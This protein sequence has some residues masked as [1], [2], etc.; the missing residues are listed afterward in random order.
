[1]MGIIRRHWG[2]KKINI[3]FT[4]ILGNIGERLRDDKDAKEGQGNA[5]G[6]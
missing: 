3:I 1:M 4:T 6:Y 2:W 5:K